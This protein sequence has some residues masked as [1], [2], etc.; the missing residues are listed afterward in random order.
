MSDKDP[1]LIRYV[2]KDKIEE[3]WEHIRDEIQRA[4]DHACGEEELQDVKIKLEN[5]IYG[6]L[7]VFIE[8]ILRGVITVQFMDYPQIRALRVVTISGYDY[9]KWQKPLDDFLTEWAREQGMQRIECMVRDGQIRALKP[10][11]YKKRY[12]FLTKDISNG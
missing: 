9:I 11:G 12:T 6:L 4:L 7:L 1:L 2:H 5:G 10:L 3:I 8:N